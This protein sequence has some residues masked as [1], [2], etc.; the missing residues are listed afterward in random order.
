MD[1]SSRYRHR[2]SGSRSAA[3]SRN[4]N[5]AASAA[6][7]RQT[8]ATAGGGSDRRPSSQNDNNERRRR[9]HHSVNE[10]GVTSLDVR[11]PHLHAGHDAARTPLQ[12]SSVTGPSPS[13][14]GQ[15]AVH[16]AENPSLAP[17][18]A[19]V[20]VEDRGP[21]AEQQP[22]GRHHHRLPAPR[23]VDVAARRTAA[24]G[25][26]VVGDADLRH[27]GRRCRSLDNVQAA[28]TA[29]AGGASADHRAYALLMIAK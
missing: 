12:T 15:A 28:A 2:G 6:A 5:S 11:S 1:G 27:L 3:V 19:V 23:L 7:D 22:S 14:S 9:R 10:A 21:A 13:T 18:V 4:V 29:F 16:D 25:S 26:A 24:R 17:P 8:T 20:G